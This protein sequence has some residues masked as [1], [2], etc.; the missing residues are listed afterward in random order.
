MGICRVFTLL[1]CVAVVLGSSRIVEAQAQEPSRSGL[2]EQ[3]QAEKVKTLHPYPISTGERIMNKVEDITVN[4]GLH[5]HPFL[6]NAYRGGGFALGAG[7][8]HHVSPYNL[9]DVRGSYSIRNYKRAEVEFMAPRMFQRRA[10]LSLLAGYREATQVGFYGIGT[11]SVKDD[12]ANYAFGRWYGSATM[13]VRPTRRFLTLRGGLELT[14][15]NQKP[16][17]GS[18]PSVE[19]VYT[20]ATLPGLN[21]TITYLH[22]QGTVGIDWRPATDYARRGGFYGVTFHDYRDSDEAFGFQQ[23]DYEVVQHFPILRETWAI[24]LRG[25]VETT[26]LKGHQEIPYFMLPSLG[27]GSNLRGYS[28]WRFRDRNSLLLQGEWRIMV[29]R[30]LDTA[31]F[32]DAGKVTR[33]TAD[34]DLEGLKHDY[35]F[36]VRFHGPLSTPLRID[37]ANSSEGLVLVFA[38]SAAF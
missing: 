4:G 22:S 12:R 29:N 3:A 11:D 9:L 10:T 15:W 25:F 28:S 33:L 23:V 31:F 36:G 14:E 17:E 6:E 24:S 34:L 32:Y 38:T 13:T 20:P 19:T 5:W 37:L 18:A 8:M 2:I 30:Y 1:A 16:G 26:W 27:G 35:G 7:Y 21:S